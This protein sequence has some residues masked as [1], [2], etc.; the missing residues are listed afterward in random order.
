MALYL[1]LCFTFLGRL[2]KV[3]QRL[4]D[5]KSKGKKYDKTLLSHRNIMLILI[6]LSLFFANDSLSQQLQF[7]SHDLKNDKQQINFG[8]L[9]TFS[10][11]FSID[12]FTHDTVRGLIFLQEGRNGRNSIK[13]VNKIH[14]CDANSGRHLWKKDDVPSKHFIQHIVSGIPV[15]EYSNRIVGYD[16]KVG[17]EIWSFQS[18][19][20]FLLDRQNSILAFEYE[21]AHN[22]R[23][24][25]H[26][27]STGL[28]RWTIEGHLRGLRNARRNALFY[29]EIIALGDTAVLLA[30]LGFSY[31]NIVDGSIWH[32]ATIWED[33]A[34]VGVSVATHNTRGMIS[35]YAA[36]GAVLYGSHVPWA[37][38]EMPSDVFLFEDGIYQTTETY[39][40]KFNFQGDS[41]WL[42]P[43]PECFANPFY[44]D[45][46][47]NDLLALQFPWIEG[48]ELFGH[49]INQDFCLSL[50]QP[51]DGAIKS[52]SCL[53]LDNEFYVDHIIEGDYIFLMTDQSVYKVSIPAGEL[54]KEQN[55]F[56][57]GLYSSDLG[58]KGFSQSQSYLLK[59]NKFERISIKYPHH[60][61]LKSSSLQTLVVDSNLD[62]IDTFREIDIYTVEGSCCGVEFI[63]NGQRSLLIHTLTSEVLEKDFS[64]K[65][66][67]EGT[68][69]YDNPSTNMI[70]IFQIENLK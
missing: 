5:I 37:E 14:L 19:S 36:D 18:G 45:F 13:P 59:E 27:P 67:M 16:P 70:E 3:I 42:S 53:S 52:I 57:H 32:N 9:R 61:M 54:I 30:G 34:S 49:R 65:A 15:N 7:S 64:P 20:Y 31:V 24:K 25:C 55:I 63:G 11:D 12:E 1:G 35:G 26:D 66:F 22:N 58:L 33:I 46:W 44:F 50:I 29:D 56:P 68:F 21:N 69:V 4:Q 23:I 10:F 38:F 2:S 40:V 43:T 28:S 39:V 6:S 51:E 8:N 48:S 60:F 47:G 41:L 62:I 17:E